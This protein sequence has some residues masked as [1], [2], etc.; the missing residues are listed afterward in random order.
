[1]RGESNQE[2]FM[3][4]IIMVV[5]SV[6]VFA[7]YVPLLSVNAEKTKIVNGQLRQEAKALQRYLQSENIVDTMMT[8]KLTYP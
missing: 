6:M 7:I 1:M 2:A 8:T 5:L 3:K 4:K